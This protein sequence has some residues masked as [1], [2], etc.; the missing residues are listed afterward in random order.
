MYEGNAAT[1]KIE[2]TIALNGTFEDIPRQCKVLR[3]DPEEDG[4]EL[5]LESGALLDIQRDAKYRCSI[6][7]KK[8]V[9]SCT[10]IV[11]D[12]FQSE[13]GDVLFFKIEN[14]FYSSAC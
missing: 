5:T 9:L 10:G 3:Y 1:L 12:R 7:T 4:I 8:E 14:G 2:K 6:K 11:K 13:E